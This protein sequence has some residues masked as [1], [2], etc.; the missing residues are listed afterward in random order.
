M[1][2]HL[3]PDLKL[4]SRSL[5][6]KLIFALFNLFLIIFKM[7]YLF[8]E[9]SQHNKP[10]YFWKLQNENCWFMRFSKTVT[11]ILAFS[12]DDLLSHLRSFWYIMITDCRHCV[13][14]SKDEIMR[15]ND[16][17]SL[18]NQQFSFCTFQKCVGLLCCDLSSKRYNISKM[19]KKMIN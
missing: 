14:I 7:L 11:S 13:P 6:Y 12:N 10:I 17:R 5:S 3:S 16:S 8:D 15:S 18:I 19:F 9:R 4:S 2:T 1:G